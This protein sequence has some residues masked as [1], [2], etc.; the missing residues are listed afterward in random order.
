MC[1]LF[2]CLCSFQ[3]RGQ[4]GRKSCLFVSFYL[5]VRLVCVYLFVRGALN[6]LTLFLYVINIL[7][8][9]S[10][11]LLPRVSNLISSCVT[12]HPCPHVSIPMPPRASSSAASTSMPPQR[13]HALACKRKHRTLPQVS[14]HTCPKGMNTAS[15]R[16]R[17]STNR[18]L[19]ATPRQHRC[20]GLRVN[21]H[22]PQH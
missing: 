7:S 8:L 11:T 13:L 14:T 22:A 16:I 4:I 19:P 20:P 12:Q 18:C 10:T 3:I 2:A 21:N 1:D 17:A 9:I 15:L 5:F 6:M